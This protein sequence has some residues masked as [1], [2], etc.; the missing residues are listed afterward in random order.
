MAQNQQFFRRK[1]TVHF[2]SQAKSNF[3]SYVRNQAAR[4]PKAIPQGGFQTVSASQL[5]QMV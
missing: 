1:S 4:V 5:K 2:C 3:H